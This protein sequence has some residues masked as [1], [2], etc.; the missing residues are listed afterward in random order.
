MTFENTG[1]CVIFSAPSGAGKTTIVHNLLRRDLGLEFSVSA[2]SR[3]PRPNEKHGEDYYFLGIEVFK[4]KIENS[5][6]I[7]WEEVYSNN[8]YGTLKSEIERIWSEGKT[9]IFDVD[10]IGGLNLKK[11]FQDKS[12][13]VFVQPP[14]YEELESRLRGRSTESEDKI[15]QRM[16]KARKELSFAKEFDTILVND[17][18]REACDAAE[19]MVREFL[20]K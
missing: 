4:S 6:F 18:L 10:V 16:S 9:V 19:I 14:S 17:N 5:E 12:F 3:D 1:K 8:F 15:N 7:E 20:E 11:L 2:C 13:A